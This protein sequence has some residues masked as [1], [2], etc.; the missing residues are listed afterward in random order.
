M[1]VAEKAVERVTVVRTLKKFFA[2]NG[3]PLEE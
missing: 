3:A 1:A 2:I